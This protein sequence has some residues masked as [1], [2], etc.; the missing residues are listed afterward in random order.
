MDYNLCAFVS[1]HTLNGKEVIIVTK[2]KDITDCLKT[3]IKEGSLHK[4]AV[5][6]VEEYKK[7]IKYYE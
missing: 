5:M 6:N 1:E 2:D 7:F 4:N 3:I